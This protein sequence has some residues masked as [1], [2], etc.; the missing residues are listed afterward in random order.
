[1]TLALTSQVFL[2]SLGHAGGGR[3]S[4]P[5]A[6]GPS[7]KHFLIFRGTVHIKLAGRVLLTK[8]WVRM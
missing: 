4:Y 6:E 2:W 1:M 7:T 3:D 5:V 8:G